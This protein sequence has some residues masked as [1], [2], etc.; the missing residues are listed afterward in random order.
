[1]NPADV[2]YSQERTFR[3]PRNQQ[4][5][6]LLSAKTRHAQTSSTRLYEQEKGKPEGFPILE[7]YMT[8]WFRWVEGG[9]SI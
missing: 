4:N 7:L 8:K 6:R 9:P 5:D 3:L 1:M 2:R